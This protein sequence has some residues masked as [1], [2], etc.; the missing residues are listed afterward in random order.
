MSNPELLTPHS[1][2][3]AIADAPAAQ[4]EPV[5][6]PLA[7]KEEADIGWTIN[8]RFL[9]QV[10]KIARQRTDFTTSMEAAEQILIAAAELLSAAPQP[11]EQATLESY[12]QMGS[13]QY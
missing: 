4:G 1:L 10:E 11:T 6:W 2:R 9:E 7:S 3:D 8:Y 12:A 5:V 13:R